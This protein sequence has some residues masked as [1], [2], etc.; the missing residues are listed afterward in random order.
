MD[1]AYWIDRQREALGKAEAAETSEARLA[2][3]EQAG[4]HSIR[5][6]QSPPFL[7]VEKGPATEGEREVLRAPAP[8]PPSIFGGPWRPSR[9]EPRS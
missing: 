5:A 1:K 4:R 2:H 8:K 9:P 3:Y 6:A 7:L